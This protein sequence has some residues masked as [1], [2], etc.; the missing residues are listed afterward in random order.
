M[1]QQD[2]PF[3]YGL[4]APNYPQ[5]VNNPQ[6]FYEQQKLQQNAWMMGPAGVK[7][8]LKKD[9]KDSHDPNDEY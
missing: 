3:S 2:Y 9:S 1:Q 4:P 7:P 8:D 5:P 6:S